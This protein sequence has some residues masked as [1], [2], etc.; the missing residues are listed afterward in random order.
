MDRKKILGSFG[1]RVH[2]IFKSRKSQ[3]LQII[4][5][6]ENFLDNGPREESAIKSWILLHSELF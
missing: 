2:A 4:N 3:E 1:K 6:S 5:P